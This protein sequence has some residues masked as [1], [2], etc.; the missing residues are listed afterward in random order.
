MRS[1]PVWDACYNP[2][3]SVAAEELL[4]LIELNCAGLALKAARLAGVVA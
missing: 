2:P 4:L 3:S 1:N